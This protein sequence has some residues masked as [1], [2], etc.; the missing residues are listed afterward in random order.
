M[1]D[2]QPS[3]WDAFNDAVTEF[4]PFG[5]APALLLLVTLVAGIYLASTPVKRPQADLQLWTFASNH[6]KSY[7]AALPAFVARSGITVDL[8]HVNPNAVTRKLRAAF[9]AGLKVPD[10]VEVENTRAGTFFR[11]PVD[12]IPFI[13][14]KPYLLQTKNAQG[15]SL[16]DRMVNNRFAL[17]SHKGR[18]YGLPHDVHPVM[19]A[20]RRDIIAAHRDRILAETGLDVGDASNLGAV[21]QTWEDFVNVGR[22]LTIPGQRYMFQLDDSVSS[23]FEL[24]LY[25]RGGDFFDAAGRVT[26]NSEIALKT[27]LWL[28]PL[29][30]GTPA[31]R[32]ADRAGGSRTSLYQHVAK[33][34]ILA[35]LCPDWLAGLTELYLQDV[36][37]KMALMPLPY[38][39]DDARRQRTTTG[40][41]TMLG[42]TIQPGRSPAQAW[43]VA[44]HIY[45]DLP[46]LKKQFQETRILPPL[47]DA[48]HGPD[49]AAYIGLDEPIAFWSGQPIGRMFA[50]LADA[51]PQRHGSPF[52]Q[53]AKGK[54]GAVVAAA[55]A[56]YR[57]HG[58]EGFEAFVRTRLQQA[59]AEIELQMRRNPF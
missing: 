36:A 46:S 35:Y 9:R 23:S 53:L 45:F 8:Q 18:I 5:V 11:G 58:R 10:L 17:Y 50:D 21:L 41:G 44:Q 40:G 24:L 12:E 28:T 27:L 37:G 15:E 32:I 56:Y 13:D 49:H 3:T 39:P 51:I 31:E 43:A 26:L 55:A 48:W 4:L 2:D 38:F 14:L 33:G 52:L 16:Y 22:V 25:Q 42:I 7:K 59:A 19:I 30:S 1:A 47:K 34:F 20:Y 29:T 6:H 54:A 57:Q